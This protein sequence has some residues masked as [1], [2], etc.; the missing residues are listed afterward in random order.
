MYAGLYHQLGMRAEK[1]RHQVVD[2]RYSPTMPPEV[3]AVMGASD[4]NRLRQ[5][6]SQHRLTKSYKKYRTRFV[7]GWRQ[8]LVT[9][10]IHG[11]RNLHSRMK[12]WGYDPR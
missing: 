5:R 8:H 10:A 2:H 11:L 9:L 6:Q 12:K 3:D 7:A 4:G 1:K